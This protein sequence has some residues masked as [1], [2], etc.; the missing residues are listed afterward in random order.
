MQR[1]SAAAAASRMVHEGHLTMSDI[2]LLYEDKDF[3]A[4]NKP[5]GMLVH[6]DGKSSETT[7]ADWFIA[8]H[9]EA[10]E[11]GEPRFFAGG[12]P[13]ARPGVVHRLDR[14]TS[15]VLLLAKTPEAHGAL[16]EQFQTRKVRKEYL[17]IVWGEWKETEGVV[18]R[19]IGRSAS[20][21]GPPRW[22]AFAKV[23]G[24]AREARTH[25]RVLSRGGGFSVVA[26]EPETGRTHQLRVH[27]QALHHPIVGD[28]LYAPKRPPALGLTRMALHAARITFRNLRGEEVTIEAPLPE[29]MA[30][31]LRKVEGGVR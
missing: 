25:W 16:K 6:P 4:V 22:S 29:D 2:P 24:K 21:K 12:V 15:G 17:A 30:Q 26:L 5:A 7:V 28:A 20:S 19:P 31:A 3:L 9:P 18:S 11:V 8:R 23:K 1:A 14:D 13:V 27:L 10:A